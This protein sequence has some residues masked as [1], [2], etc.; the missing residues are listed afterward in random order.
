MCQCASH[1]GAPRQHDVAKE[2]PGAGKAG[3]GLERHLICVRGGRRSARGP[4]STSLRRR[5]LGDRLMGLGRRGR[6]DET[7][8]RDH[9][10]LFPCDP[11]KSARE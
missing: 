9:M 6:G 1:R 5:T 2:A 4:S 8:L 10:D 11:L 7:D 3:D